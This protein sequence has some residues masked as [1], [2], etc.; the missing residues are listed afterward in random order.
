MES[1]LNDTINQIRNIVKD[2]TITL[3]ISG[4][5]DSTV[6]SILLH[7]AIGER[8]TCLFI[9]NGLLRKNESDEI[10]D[11]YKKHLPI[12]VKKID[13]SKLFL[14]RLKKYYKS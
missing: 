3:G 11:A 6:L 10:I 2:K 7:K 13:E 12:N 9:D 4:G 8:L 14:D 1:F 5:V